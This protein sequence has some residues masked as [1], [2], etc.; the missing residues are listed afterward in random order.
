MGTLDTSRL[1][2]VRYVLSGNSLKEAF[3]YAE[4]WIG[5]GHR[6]DLKCPFTIN[7][8]VWFVFVYES[9]SY[10]FTRTKLVE[11]RRNTHTHQYLRR[12]LFG[13]ESACSLEA[14]RGRRKAYH[15]F[16]YDGK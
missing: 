13:A 10:K 8:V 3:T 4:D 9:R 5:V 7:A 6:K 11:N 16:K 2:R 14:K 15:S 12:R 1:V